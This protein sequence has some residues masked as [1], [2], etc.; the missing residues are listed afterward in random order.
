MTRGR[1]RTAYSVSAAT[2]RA[3]RSRITCS[4][5]RSRP[6][7]ASVASGQFRRRREVF[8]RNSVP[9]VHPGRLEGHRPTDAQ[10]RPASRALPAMA[11]ASGELRS[12]ARTASCLSVQPG[13]LCPRRGI[14]SRLRRAAA[15]RAADRHRHERFRA[16]F[17]HRLPPGFDDGRSSRLRRFH[18]H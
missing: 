3:T 7:A 18:P 14:D 4:A 16:A 15:A 17:R 12:G 10:Y 5:F 11:R 1:T 13:L 6:T 2:S 9:V 8:D